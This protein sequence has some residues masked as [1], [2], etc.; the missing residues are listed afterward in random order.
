MKIK[1]TLTVRENGIT[2]QIITT[3]EELPAL[4]GVLSS[5]D[6]EILLI[7]Y[8]EELNPD[9]RNLKNQIRRYLKQRGISK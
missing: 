2:H 7:E 3:P 9:E 4:L 8:D 1:A 6:V 5:N